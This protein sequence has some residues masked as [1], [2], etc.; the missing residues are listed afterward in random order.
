MKRSKYFVFF[1]QFW[2]I[3]LYSQTPVNLTTNNLH[4]LFLIELEKI[5]RTEP[6]QTKENVEGSPFLSED[7]QNG[8]VKT[9]RGVYNPKR[10]RYNIFIDAIQFDLGN[11][12]LYL[13][14]QSIIEEVKLGESILKV[15]VY[16]Y[17]SALNKGFLV[18]LVSGKFSLYAKKNITYREAEAPKALESVGKPPKYVRL[19]DTY[20]LEM[21]D[22]K[23]LKVSNV[24]DI[25]ELIDKSDQLLEYVKKQKIGG[26]K[27]EDLILVIRKANTIF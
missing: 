17:K 20:F 10:M 26:K 19:S 21:P 15:K 16:P 23:M 5:V 14:P 6:N 12:L 24:K 8:E 3:T 18:E 7:F 9:T 13:D 22:G 4:N 1:A 25:V 27:E 11:Q 2:V